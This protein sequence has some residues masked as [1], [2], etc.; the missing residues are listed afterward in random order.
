MLLSLRWALHR[1]PVRPLYGHGRIWG[2]GLER[3]TFT[4]DGDL[5][6]GVAAP[7]AYNL[8]DFSLV[9]TTTSIPLGSLSG[10]QF[11]SFSQPL[12]G[13]IW[14]GAAPTQFFR[15]SGVRT[16]GFGFDS[17]PPLLGGPGSN[18]VF[19]INDFLIQ[20]G[21]STIIIESQTINLNPLAPVPEPST[22]VLL[23]IG[24][25][26]IAGFARKR[27]RKKS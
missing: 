9:A 21:G 10:G 17:I 12:F 4:T 15:D 23:G 2:T 1:R 13:F 5:V 26:G 24:L 25:V 16:D 19:N 8:I 11:V 14:D 22:V 3:G 7:G 20:D 6:G 27:D 18:L